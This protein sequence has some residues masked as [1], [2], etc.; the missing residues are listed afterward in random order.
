MSKSGKKNSLFF[1]LFVLKNIASLS[2]FNVFS[3]ASN[4]CL[5][6]FIAKDKKTPSRPLIFILCYKFI[7]FFIRL[8]PRK[9]VLQPYFLTIVI[10]ALF[11]NAVNTLKNFSSEFDTILALFFIPKSFFF[12]KATEHN[13][14]FLLTSLAHIS[15]RDNAVRSSLRAGKNGRQIRKK[16]IFVLSRLVNLIV[17]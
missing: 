17:C 7:G 8:L 9:N 1:I 16:Y 14:A 6:L 15:A 2:S 10:I 12:E 11:H 13:S 3:K 5:A 4:A